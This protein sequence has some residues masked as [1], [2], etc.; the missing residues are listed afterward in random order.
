MKPVELSLYPFGLVYRHRFGLL[1]GQH[2]GLDFKRVDAL[3]NLLAYL[4]NLVGV[5]VHFYLSRKL[6]SNA[7]LGGYKAVKF[8]FGRFFGFFFIVCHIIIFA[9]AQD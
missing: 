4:P 6:A 2:V 8:F 3:A 9:K 5:S 7:F 1:A